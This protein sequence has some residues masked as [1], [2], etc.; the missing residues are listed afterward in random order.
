MLGQKMGAERRVA[1]LASNIFDQSD[2]ALIIAKH[3]NQ[4]RGLSGGNTKVS[5]RVLGRTVRCF[6]SKLVAKS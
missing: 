4:K 5:L 3:E 6:T 2:C 1:T